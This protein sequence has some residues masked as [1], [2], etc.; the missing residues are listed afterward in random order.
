MGPVDIKFSK[1]NGLRLCNQL[2]T[3]LNYKAQN[4]RLPCS[5]DITKNDL[6][7]HLNTCKVNK[8]SFRTV[9]GFNY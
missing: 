8:E 4:F 9:W 2:Q 6:Y 1:S 7:C 5:N 3:L